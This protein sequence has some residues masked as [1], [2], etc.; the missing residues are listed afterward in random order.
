M[1]SVERSHRT[2]KVLKVSRVKVRGGLVRR[3][4]ME[5]HKYY[6]LL[7]YLQGD[8]KE[9]KKY[10]EWAEQFTEKGGQVFKGDK[11]LIPRSQVLRVI[12]I[13]HDLP[14]AAHQSKDAVWDQIR[15]RYIW[16]GMYRDVEEYVKIYYKC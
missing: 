1:D 11:R 12:S 5:D 4:V 9:G 8:R 16:D 14:T 13:F 15:K 10:M 7:E 6:Q 2:P 3:V